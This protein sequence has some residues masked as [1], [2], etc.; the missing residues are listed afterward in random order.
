L[1]LLSV[2]KAQ[3]LAAALTDDPNERA[4]FREGLRKTGEEVQRVIPSNLDWAIEREFSG[5]KLISF[6]TYLKGTDHIR[7]RLDRKG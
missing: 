4:T 2:G 7:E 3:A 5:E 6:R 1:S